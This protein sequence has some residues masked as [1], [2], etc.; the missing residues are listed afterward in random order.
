M[1]I[2][3][4]LVLGSL[5]HKARFTRIAKFRVMRNELNFIFRYPCLTIDISL[6]AEKIRIGASFQNSQ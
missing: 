3:T 5:S 6:P 1:R 2:S 4:K